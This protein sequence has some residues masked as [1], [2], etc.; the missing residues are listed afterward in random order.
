MDALFGHILSTIR[1]T[2]T[3]YMIG[4]HCRANPSQFCYFVYPLLQE[5]F[6][7]LLILSQ[8]IPIIVLAPLLVI[9]FGFGMLPKVIVIVL[10]CFFP[11]TIAALMVYGKHDRDVKALYENDR[12]NKSTNFLEACN[13]H[14]P[15]FNIFRFK[16]CRYI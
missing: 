15:P 12:C 16:N 1:L 3:G 5:A 11:I 7:P 2:L 13:G 10:V 14:M 9:W 8:N 6:Y 4:S